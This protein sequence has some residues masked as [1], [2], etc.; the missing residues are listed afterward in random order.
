MITYNRQNTW[1]RM[2]FTIILFFLIAGCFIPN[3]HAGS[4]NS[5]RTKSVATDDSQAITISSSTEF[6]AFYAK[7]CNG[8]TFAGQLVVLDKDIS[9]DTGGNSGT[10]TFEG[11]FDGQD[12]KLNDVTASLFTINK[13]K[14]EICTLPPDCLTEPEY[15]APPT[16]G[17]L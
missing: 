6:A 2:R 17:T 1:M 13:P 15:S 4:I 11:T 12:H 9:F 10:R 5:E 8:N 16:P 7:L 14:S 3:I